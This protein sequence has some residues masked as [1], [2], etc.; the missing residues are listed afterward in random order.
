MSS[1]RR[2]LLTAFVVS[3]CSLAV[4]LSAT[5]L[6]VAEP[7][8]GKMVLPIYG[9]APAVWNTCMVFYQAVFLGGYL[10]AHLLGKM[11]RPAVQVGLHLLLVT[12][13]GLTLPFLIIPGLAAEGSSP[14]I[15]LLGILCQSAAAPLFAL[16]TTAPLIQHWFSLSCQS[17]S[18]DPYF[19]YAASNLG[20]LAGLFLFPFV[21]EPRLD[22][23]LISSWWETGYA[24]LLFCLSLAGVLLAGTTP[25]ASATDMPLQSR[26]SVGRDRIRPSQVLHWVILSFIPSSL[27]LGVTTY[28]STDVAAVPLLWI[29]PLALYLLSFV[30]AFGSSLKVH[31]LLRERTLCLLAVVLI[32]AW[33][34]ESGHPAWLLIPLHLLFFWCATLTL[35]MQLAAVRPHAS[36]LT[37]YYLCMSAGG[38]LGGAMNTFLAPSLF[39]SILEY[40]L[41]MA[42]ACTMYAG[43]RQAWTD[44]SAWRRVL[45]QAGGLLLLLAVL[46]LLGEWFQVPPGRAN[47]LLVFAPAALFAYNQVGRPGLYGVLLL[48]LLLSSYF[49]RSVH[50]QLLFAERSFFGVLRVTE[51]GPFHVLVHGNTQHGRQRLSDPGCNPLSYYYASGPAGSFIQQFSR[52]PEYQRA[53]VG[54]IGLG[55]GALTCYGTSTQR[56]TY[57]EI[58]PA[59]TSV[60]RN[61]EFFTF[62]SRSPTTEVEVQEG[63][64]RLTLRA[65][66]RGQFDLLVLD[67][68][69]SDS[70]PM[71]LVTA[72]SFELYL[73]TLSE[74]GVM[75][76][77]IS[78]RFLDLQPVLARLGEHAGLRVYRWDDFYVS[79]QESA[80][81]KD[82]SQWMLFT[83]RDLSWVEEGM[84][85]Q[86]IKAAGD[87]PLWTDRYSNIFSA[88]RGWNELFTGQESP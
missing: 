34:T 24:L 27:M 23:T 85:W 59:V 73:H 79:A 35:H 75:L 15:V 61:P 20:S 54:V 30:A 25:A 47:T 57:F 72:E 26:V 81:G 11:R 29:I 7:L 45:G 65:A 2:P 40:P 18:R 76:F 13:A 32:V 4:L 74:Q 48:V 43:G 39:Q 82:P 71:H 46:L 52:R 49:Y 86:R 16:A 31:S 19:L 80:A 84:S 68:F 8:I 58:N 9:G 22:T 50:G 62:L 87:T 64:A 70:I 38:V 66:R 36:Q 10:Y 55:T 12:G 56:W 14:V 28:I 5:L 53:G 77:H 78:N 69:S 21:L 1:A 6:F 63:D 60:A 3:V 42:A 83:R 51:S 88:L 33:I 67:A 17:N 37:A 44:L 41:M